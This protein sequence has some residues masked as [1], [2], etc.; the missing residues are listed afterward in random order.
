MPQSEFFK[1]DHFVE[2]RNHK[3]HDLGADA[4]KAMLTNVAPSQANTQF[5]SDLTD[6][7]AG[8]GYT[9]GGATITRISSG[10]VNGLYRLILE[11]VTITA[12]GGSI[13]P[14]RWVVLYN[15]SAPS[16]EVIGF[17]D[18]SNDDDDEHFTLDAGERTKIDLS[19]VTGVLSDQ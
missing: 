13:G 4:L 19:Q 1:F 9:A 7:A 18:Y 14:F 5:F 12:S 15:D 3:K 6:I 17:F 16:K 8:N 2:A 10:Q 11:D